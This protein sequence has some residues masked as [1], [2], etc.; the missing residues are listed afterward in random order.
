MT[1]LHVNEP[2]TA[3]A[4]A[5]KAEQEREKAQALRAARRR[6]RTIQRASLGYHLE[7]WT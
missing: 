3:A 4:T 5:L 6:A 2:L 7:Q 1:T